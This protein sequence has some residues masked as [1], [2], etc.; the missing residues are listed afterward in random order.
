[1]SSNTGVARVTANGSGG[2]IV[3]AAGIGF[4]NVVVTDAANRSTTVP[5][6][7]QTVSL[8]VN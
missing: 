7:V 5:V 1:M 3:T 2:F 6:S 4:C 8:I